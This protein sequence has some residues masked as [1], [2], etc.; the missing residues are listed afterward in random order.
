MMI[1]LKSRNFREQKLSR[2]KTFANGQNIIFAS[3]NFREFFRGEFFASINFRELFTIKY[4]ACIYFREH[5]KYPKQNQ[6]TIEYVPG[7]KDRK[8]TLK[9]KNQL[10]YWI[11]YYKATKFF[12]FYGALCN[13]W[14]SGAQTK[15]T[16]I[17]KKQ[18]RGEGY[19]NHQ[20]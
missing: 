9:N 16:R 10:Q 5:P 1:Y 6:G 18:T 7:Y 3:I 14:S 17:I 4:F 19:K 20:N 2:A 8:Y 11:F 13:G 15:R 12:F